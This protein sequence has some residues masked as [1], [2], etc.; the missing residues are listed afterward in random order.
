MQQEALTRWTSENSS[1]LY[2]VRNW[3]R[4]FFDVSKTGEMLVRP[5]G[6]N[7]KMTVSLMDIVAEMEKREIGMPALIRF[8]DILQTRIQHVNERFRK[9][10]SEAGY[11]GQ[12]RGV[13]PVKVNQQ[14]KVVESIIKFGREYNHG[15]E[16]GS[17]AELI[18]AAAYMEDEQAL[19]IC[20]GYKDEEF[21]DLALQTQKLGMKVLI[22]IEMPAELELIIERAELLNVRPNLGVRAK[23]SSRAGGRWDASGGDRS[24]F[25][26]DSAQIIEM[27]DYLRERNKLDC[28]QMLHYHLGSQIPDIR[29]VRN[30]LSEAARFYAALVKE[31]AAMGIIDVGGGLAIDYDGSHTNFPSSRNYSTREYAVDVVEVIMNVCDESKIPHPM[32]VSESGRAVVAHHSVLIFN[33]L[34]VRKF[35]PQTIPSKLD[36]DSPEML[37]NIKEVCD[38]LNPRNT[39][40]AYHDAV[41]YRDEIRAAFMQ[42]NVSLRERAMAETIFWHIIRRIAKL[43]EGQKY[44]PDEMERLDQAIA[45]VY[46]GNFSVFQS[47]SDAWALDQ[48]FPITPIHRLNERPTRQAVLAD[49]TCDSDGK[50][51]RFIDLHDVSHTVPLHELN[52]SDYYV[53]IFLVGA[54]QETLG[55]MHNLLGDINVMLVHAD[56][57]TETVKYVEE[58]AGDTVAKVLSYVEYDAD[59][60]MKQIEASTNR[61]LSAGSI[62]EKEKQEILDAYQ[63]G[64]E[65]YTY[66]EK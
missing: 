38:T 37:H 15:L 39:Q 46:Y 14:F 58:I 34:D 59:E 50:V 55:D 43:I 42:G 6:R 48:L 63:Y 44:I 56:Q 12:Y 41:Y 64:M 31:G 18:A 9:A 11:K 1:E 4:N 3:G 28:L 35:D 16:V 65:G 17:K 13:Y 21:V 26:L 49:I 22:V 47:I 10:I 25:G 53:G 45:D 60:V 5:G 51:D 8:P 52:D 62:S 29:K 27:V 23:L 61:A 40:E 66:F 57:E 24:K 33:I 30:A 36:E 20:N 7:S 2:G 32:I 54:Y 19:L